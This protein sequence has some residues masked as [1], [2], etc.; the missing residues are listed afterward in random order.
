MQIGLTGAVRS[1]PRVY[2]ARDLIEISSDCA[3]LADSLLQRLEFVVGDGRK[4]SEVGTHQQG[5][6]SGRSS[7]ANRTDNR[8]LT[9]TCPN[10][11]KATLRTSLLPIS[12]STTRFR[13]ADSESP[14][15]RANSVKRS[16]VSRE[17]H[18]FK[19]LLPLIV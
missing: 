9:G 16:F 5:D 10:G 6:V 18:A 19:C 13:S 4:V 7:T 3:H 8:P 12:A 1:L 11:A 15:P 17:T 14:C 2:R